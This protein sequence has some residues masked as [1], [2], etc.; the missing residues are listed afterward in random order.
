MKDAEDGG[1]SIRNRELY[2]YSDFLSELRKFA[3]DEPLRVCARRFLLSCGISEERI[4][5]IK[6]I[7][8]K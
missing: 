5:K 2:L 6:S 7:I 3:P 8:R 4:E 1:F